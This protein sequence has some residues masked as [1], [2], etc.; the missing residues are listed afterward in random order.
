MISI[1]RVGVLNLCVC[2]PVP[3]NV[4]ESS[5]GMFFANYGA[6]GSVKVR[7]SSQHSPEHVDPDTEVIVLVCRLCG[8]DLTRFRLLGCRSR[9]GR[10]ADSLRSCAGRTPSGPSRSWTES[11]GA[12]T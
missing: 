5:L 3:A 7:A 12:G 10:W 4:I 11:S 9:A 6:V 2:C 1:A 8:P